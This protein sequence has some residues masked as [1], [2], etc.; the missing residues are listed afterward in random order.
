MYVYIYICVCVCVCV[1][2]FV[3]VYNE[4]FLTF[5]SYINLLK[6]TWPV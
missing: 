6:M 4:A 5:T 2:V 1:C 3:C